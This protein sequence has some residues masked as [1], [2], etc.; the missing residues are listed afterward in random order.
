MSEENKKEPILRVEDL[1][2]HFNAGGGLFKPKKFVKAV[3]GVSFEIQEGET[4]GLVG[5]SGCGKSTTGRAIVKSIIRQR[6]RYII[7][8]RTSHQ[9]K[10]MP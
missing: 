7:K 9:S 5:E 6:E 8:V 1:K 10:E 3:D 4:F 2:V